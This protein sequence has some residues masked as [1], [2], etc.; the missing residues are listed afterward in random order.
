MELLRWK[1]RI[2]V[3]WVAMA[4]FISAHSLLAYGAPGM[5]EKFI[6]EMEA[7]GAGMWVFM[8]CFWLFPLWLAFLTM[9]LK[10]SANRWVNLILGIIFTILNIF[11][12]FECGVPLIEGGM[13]E[14][15]A[16][17][18]LIVGSTVVAAALIA[19]YAWKWPK[20]EA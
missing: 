18:I 7:G 20:Q 5:L 6:S 15:T 17:H 2:A 3:L 4:V 9:T 13:P 11:H 12:F 19:W 8:A 10:G 16:H 14:A 1:T